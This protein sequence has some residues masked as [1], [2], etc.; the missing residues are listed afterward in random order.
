MILSGAPSS[1]M[2]HLAG[3]A[4]QQHGPSGIGNHS[5][6]PPDSYGDAAALAGAPM[7]LH[8]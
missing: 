7:V 5:R 8:A 2:R 4:P 6:D 1:T 3:A